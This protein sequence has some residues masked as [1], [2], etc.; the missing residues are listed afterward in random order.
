MTISANAADNVAVDHVDLLVDGTTMGTIKNAPYQISYDSTSLTNGPHTISARA[1]DSSG[2]AKTS[3]AVAV[4]VNNAPA[5][6]LPPPTG[7]VFTTLAS[8]AAGLPRTTCASQMTTSTWEPISSNYTANHSVPAGPVPWSNAELG[9][10]WAKWIAKRNL[11]TGNY[12]GTTNQII[13]WSACKWGMDEDLMR[14]VAVQE[15]DW[16]E[17]MVGDNC[18]RTG[19]ASYGLFQIKNAYCSG[20]D[21]WGGYPYSATYTALNADFY[22]AY[23][24]SCLDGDFYAS[25]NSWLYNGQSMPQII[26]A[27]GLDYAVWGCVGSWFSGGWYDSG[28][29]N[30][31]NGVKGHLA[32]KDWLKY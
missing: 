15:S 6:Q 14:A 31:I 13:Q 29:Q 7:G 8:G 16:R 1:V 17:S 19:Q 3:A 10:Y 18:G 25:G 26:A 27:K 5:P 4:T 2:N 32:N 23:L 30:Y 21:A 9:P 22:G 28:A 11:V 20:A 12:T 24:R